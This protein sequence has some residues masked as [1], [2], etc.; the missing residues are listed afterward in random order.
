MRLLLVGFQSQQ[1]EAAFLSHSYRHT[2]Y[3][4]TAAALLFLPMVLSFGV[5]TDP[6]GA[7]VDHRGQLLLR[8]LFVGLFGVPPVLLLL[9]RSR[10]QLGSR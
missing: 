1:Q 2:A 3:A 4:D 8:L 10:L 9:V 5:L 6:L 7:A